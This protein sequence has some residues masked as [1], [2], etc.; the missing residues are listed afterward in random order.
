MPIDVAASLRRQE[1]GWFESPVL[2][3]ARSAFE[4]RDLKVSVCTEGRLND[5]SYLANVSAVV[6]IFDVAAKMQR[7]ARAFDKH[8]KRLLDYG[9]SAIVVSGRTELARLR[10]SV[11]TLNL[12]INN[13]RPEGS[14]SWEWQDL[15]ASQPGPNVHYFDSDLNDKNKWV[16]IANMVAYRQVGDRPNLVLKVAGA[17]LEADEELL[18]R[19]AF[20]GD[21]TSVHLDS[22][23]RG[24]SGARVFRAQTETGN[25]WPVPYFVKIDK[26]QRTIDEY[27][28]YLIGVEPSVPF[29][30]APPI[31]KERCCLG[32]ARGIIVGQYIGESESLLACAEGG[33]AIS[34]VSCLFSRTLRIWH[35]SHDPHPLIEYLECKLPKLFDERNMECAKVLGA[36]REPVELRKSILT[37]ATSHARYGSIHGDLNISNVRVR[38]GDAIII[39]PSEYSSGPLLWDPAFLEAS[40]LVEGFTQERRDVAAWLAAIAPCYEM[41][42]FNFWSHKHLVDEASWF[43][44]TVNQI[45][46]YA[47]EMECAEGQ[48]GVTLAVALL[49]MAAKPARFSDEN[50]RESFRRGAA[51]YLA[52]RLLERLAEGSESFEQT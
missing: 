51:Y 7:M 22:E 38:G 41:P 21:V 9:C 5:A 52:E 28:N 24:Y 29:H 20:G 1:V 25:R 15:N 3:D 34:A 48:Y 40:L 50:K 45:R 11:Q 44:I 30:L 13:L 8:A 2:D 12:P 43:H 49:F 35:R 14:G 33:R 32:S 42:L 6:F 36:R 16:A 19:R 37:C 27:N 39:D 26:R 46:L 18:L 17:G 10:Q 23:P 4:Q 31:L 47:K